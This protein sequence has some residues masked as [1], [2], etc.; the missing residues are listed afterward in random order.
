MPLTPFNGLKPSLTNMSDLPN[1]TQSDSTLPHLMLPEYIELWQ[2]TIAWSPSSLQ[3]AQ[4]QQLLTELYLLNQSVNLTR[5][6]DPEAFWEKHLWD[7][8]WGVSP[9]LTADATFKATP[10]PANQPIRVIDIGT[11]GGFPG[12]PVAIAFPNWQVTLLDSTHKKVACLKTLCQNLPLTNA[13][14]VCDRAEALGQKSSDRAA[15]DLALVRAV[16]PVSSCA[17]YALPLLKIGGTAVLYRGQWSTEEE[18]ILQKALKQLGG[19]LLELRSTTTPLTHGQRHGL[20]L[21]KVYSTSPTYPRKEGLPAKYPL[22]MSPNDSH[23][24]KESKS[25]AIA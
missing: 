20:Y 23:P 10:L 25:S 4:F 17:E 15:F 19:E 6:T 3:Q 13:Y 2:S 22:G 12:Y 8:L 11:G 1:L 18:Q 7:S 24:A 21:R 14:P 9:W 5:I 16:G